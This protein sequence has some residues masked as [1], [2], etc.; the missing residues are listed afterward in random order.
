MFFFLLKC[1]YIRGIL[2]IE[3]EVSEMKNTKPVY[4]YSLDGKFIREFATTEECGD[5]F[6]KDKEYINHNLKYY[7]KIRKDGVWYLIK[8][9]RIEDEQ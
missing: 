2:K 8:R 9:K 1:I 6:D 7:K 5:Y 4:L 3:K